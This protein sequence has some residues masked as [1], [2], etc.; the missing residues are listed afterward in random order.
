MKMCNIALCGKM[1]L[2][3]IKRLPPMNTIFS[4]VGK[5]EIYLMPLTKAFKAIII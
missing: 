2:K 3:K 5:I 4:T 1:T